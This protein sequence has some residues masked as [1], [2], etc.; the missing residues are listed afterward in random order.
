MANI[1]IDNMTGTNWDDIIDRPG[2]LGATWTYHPSASPRWYLYNNQ[3]HCGV[4]GPAFANGVPPT[5][6]YTVECKYIIYTP[7][8]SLNLGIAGRM[9][10]GA[11]TYYA[12]YYQSGELVLMKRVAGVTTSLGTWISAL[13]GGGASYDFSLEMI[14]TAIKAYVNGV[15][16]ISATDSAIAAAGRAGIRS[17]GVNDAATGHHI[18]NFKASDSSIAAAGRVFA[19]GFVGI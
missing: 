6:N 12:L 3:V 1:V 13:S 16:R 17:I 2:E 15:Q 5:A 8:P 7:I 11:D 9:D 14:G 4:G 19:S 18:D 10:V